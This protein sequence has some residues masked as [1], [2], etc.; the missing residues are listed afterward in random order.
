MLVNSRADA[1]VG[2]WNGLCNV[3]EKVTVQSHEVA[4]FFSVFSGLPRMGQ[5]YVATGETTLAEGEWSVT[6]G[7]VCKW[8]R[9]L[10]QEAHGFRFALPVATFLRPIR[11]V[12][13]SICLGFGVTLH[14]AEGLRF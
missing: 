4:S 9:L 1:R 12:P 13:T 2:S 11:G 6:R 3:R 8:K 7:G 14:K 5:R 10:R